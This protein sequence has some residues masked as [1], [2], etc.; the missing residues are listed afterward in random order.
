MA[1]DIKQRNKTVLELLNGTLGAIKT[2]VPLDFGL[3]KPFLLDQS[4]QMSFGVLIGFTG[5]LK[6]KLVLKGNEA[7]FGSIGEIMFGMA[8]E[9]EMLSS[10]AGELGNMIA[11]G[12]AT[13]LAEDGVFIDITS[14]TVM[15][16]DTALLGFEK[17]IGV[18]LSYPNI[19]DMD[20]YLV[21]DN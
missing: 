13:N 17:A 7:L 19:G 8:L 15:K 18:A 2:V 20:I 21:L 9:G 5:D 10:F 12:M 16:G 11:G 14:P 4:L 6:G 3:G 1:V